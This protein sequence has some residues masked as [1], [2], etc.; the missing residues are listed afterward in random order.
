[1]KAF[2]VISQAFC[3]AACATLVASFGGSGTV[4][5]TTAISKQSALTNPLAMLFVSATVRPCALILSPSRMN[6]LGQ[7][8]LSTS[9]M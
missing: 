8:A 9:L 3:L 6:D 1:M 2:K 4:W 5:P 7:K